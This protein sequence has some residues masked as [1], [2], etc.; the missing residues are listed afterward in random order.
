MFFKELYYTGADVESDDRTT[1]KLYGLGWTKDALASDIINT[2][3]IKDE[4]IEKEVN[5]IVKTIRTRE[6]RYIISKGVKRDEHEDLKIEHYYLKANGDN[7]ELRK[8]RVLMSR[9]NGLSTRLFEDTTILVEKFI[10][11]LKNGCIYIKKHDRDMSRREIERKADVIIDIEKKSI[12]IL[13]EI[14]DT[15]EADEINKIINK[16]GKTLKVMFARIEEKYIP[17]T[18]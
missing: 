17:I 9:I 16:L 13:Y 18:L 15:R 6:G 7:Y 5:E 11:L 2:I 12:E 1:E 8:A 10:V 3:G 4:E 14:E